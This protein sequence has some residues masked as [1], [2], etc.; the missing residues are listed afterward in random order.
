MRTP[1]IVKHFEIFCRDREIVRNK[2]L[3]YLISYGIF[4]S[5]N[6]FNCYSYFKFKANPKELSSQNIQR[7]FRTSTIDDAKEVHR[8]GLK[9]D[10]FVFAL[11]NKRLKA[12]SHPEELAIG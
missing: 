11:S 4:L 1:T 5:W 3:G 12:T 9:D 10:E 2:P 7:E 6:P 8:V